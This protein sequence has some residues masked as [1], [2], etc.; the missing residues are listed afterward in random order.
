MNSVGPL[1]LLSYLPRFL[2][3]A[4]LIVA[5]VLAVVRRS[6][7]GAKAFSLMMAGLGVMILALCATES[8]TTFGYK[9]LMH[10]ASPAGMG[11][12]LMVISSVTTLMWLIGLGLVLGAA[13]ADRPHRTEQP[14]A[15]RP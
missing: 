2:M 14:N 5:L 9:T 1:Y 13:F 15:P 3:L 10:T 11:G 6:Q 12:L 8:F 4:G 7:L